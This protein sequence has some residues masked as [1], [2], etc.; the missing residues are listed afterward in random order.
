MI[1]SGAEC[2]LLDKDGKTAIQLASFETTKALNVILAEWSA[3]T[4]EFASEILEVSTY[5]RSYGVESVT[6]SRVSQQLV[7]SHKI[8]SLLE[9]RKLCSE[10]GDKMKNLLRGIGVDSSLVNSIVGESSCVLC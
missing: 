2:N 3:R 5:L 1:A 10:D 9:M 4:A 7:I 8:S 6:A